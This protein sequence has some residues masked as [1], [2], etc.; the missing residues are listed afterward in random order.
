M[1]S[2]KPTKERA[3]SRHDCP[4][5]YRVWQSRSAPDKPIPVIVEETEG[6]FVATFLDGAIGASGETLPE[7]IWSLREIILMKYR[8]FSELGPSKIGAIPLKQLAVL[9]EFITGE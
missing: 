3:N 4:Q 2:K 6:D 8:R 1:A 7:A 9:R 5:S